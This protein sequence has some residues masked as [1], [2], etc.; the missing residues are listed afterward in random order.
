MSLT[1]RTAE[2]T[3]LPAIRDIYN[4][5]VTETHI[6]FD[7][8]PVNLANRTEWA[9]QFSGDRYQLI[10][11]EHQGEVM[12][13]ACSSRLRVKPAY[14]RSV[15]TT[16]YLHHAAGGRGFGETLYAELFRRLG[17]T[18]VHR[19]YGVIALPNDA[20]VAL[21]R[22]FGFSDAGLLTEVGYKFDRYWDTLWME[23]EI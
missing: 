15:E 16:I 12:G 1:V 2:P 4:H 19:C 22:K 20:S 13:Y 23:R 9:R 8:D 21:H 7:L 18:D 14:D 17:E 11:G 10:V 6:T 5:Y 3:D